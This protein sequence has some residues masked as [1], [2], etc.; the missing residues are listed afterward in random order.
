MIEPIVEN[1]RKSR[2]VWL[3]LKNSKKMIDCQSILN[4]WKSQEFKFIEENVEFEKAGLRI[5][6]IG[7]LYSLLGYLKSDNNKP[8][9]IVMPTGTGK[10]EV[11]LSSI[12]AGKFEKTLIIVPSDALREQTSDKLIKSGLLREL[13]LITEEF[14]NP[15]VA[16]IKHGLLEEDTSSILKSNVIIAT[17][18]ALSKVSS[19]VLESFSQNCSHLIIDEAHHVNASTWLTIRKSFINKPI[20]QFTATPFRTDATRIEG[21]IIFNYP[22]R[23]A[24]YDGYFMPIE[25]HPIKEFQTS[26]VDEAIAE[27]AI[28]ILRNDLEAGLDHIMMARANNIKRAKKIF[29]IYEH[30]SDL[31][32]ILITSKEKNK[33]TILAN[34]RA[35]KHKI[36]ICVD[37][38]GEGFD[39]P[40]LKI[41]AI[42]DPHKSINILLQFT[43]RF[44]RTTK[45]N[46]GN[47]KFIANIANPNMSDSLIELYQE[48]SDWNVII[49]GISHNK[50]SDEKRYQDFRSEFAEKH[51]LLDLGLMP[52]VSTTIYKVENEVHLEN[53]NLFAK[54]RLKITEYAVNDSKNLLIFTT[55]T[56]MPVKWTTSKELYD[57]IWDLYIAFYSEEQNLLFI[58]TSSKDAILKDLVK[59]LTKDAEQITG[60]VIFRSLDSI[61]RLVLQNIGLNKNKQGL[62]YRCLST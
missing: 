6:Q 16:I 61:K 28:S 17:A 15:I 11:I 49:E 40:Q 53:F 14:L 50:I 2:V 42:H 39:L 43:G 12:I 22:L 27:K 10:T 51:K 20:L 9:T 59:S 18:S 4:S 31:N 38:L 48:N 26:K 21:K 32:P 19:T 1:I 36:I 25:F 5:P 24:Q 47:A 35:G 23:Q 37:M 57:E 44:T 52:N 62:R 34:I 33:K 58:H 56:N 60:D 30:E 13:G 54:G 29:E 41:A 45:K 46:I 7:A 3:P 8:A 55:L